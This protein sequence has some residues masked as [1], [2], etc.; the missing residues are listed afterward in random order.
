MKGYEIT[1]KG[2]WIREETDPEDLTLMRQ[3]MRLSRLRGELRGDFHARQKSVRTKSDHQA[4]VGD[5]EVTFFLPSRRYIP[6]R[7]VIS[8]GKTLLK[9]FLQDVTCRPPILTN[10]EV[11]YRTWSLRVPDWVGGYER[12]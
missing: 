12:A 7:S 6:H 11:E 8:R 10:V 5:F 2:D 4:R 9:W 3:S 1:L